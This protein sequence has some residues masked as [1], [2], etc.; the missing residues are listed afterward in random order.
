[1]NPSQTFR[2]SLKYDC[3]KTCDYGFRK[4]LAKCLH[5]LERCS[6]CNDCERNDYSNRGST[7]W[8]SPSCASYYYPNLGRS[9]VFFIKK[10]EHAK[11]RAKFSVYLIPNLSKVPH[12]ITVQ[13]DDRIERYTEGYF[14]FLGV[15]NTGEEAA[16]QVKPLVDVIGK[17]EG[18]IEMK[19]ILPRLEQKI[20]AR[21]ILSSQEFDEIPNGFAYAIWADPNISEPNVKIDGLA[22]AAFVLCFTFKDGNQICIPSEGNPTILDFPV[23]Y[24]LE[25]YLSAEG[26]PRHYI[27]AYRCKG[28]S[29]DNCTVLP[30]TQ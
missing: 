18:L 3:Q 8:R 6:C 13:L 24:V 22:T 12:R 1:M 25:V 11:V 7:A 17:Y 2:R 26:L 29:W 15:T 14:H 10:W 5:L 30:E 23:D 9:L 19:V 21:S 20:S 16:N 27:G 4:L 28:N